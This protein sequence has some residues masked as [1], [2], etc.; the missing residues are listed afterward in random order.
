MKYSFA[1]LFTTAAQA[2]FLSLEDAPEAPVWAKAFKQD[3]TEDVK[4]PVIGEHKTK[5]TYYFDVS[6]ESN[7]LTRIDRDNGDYDRYCGLTHHFSAGACQQYITNGDRYLHYTKDDDCCYC[8][9]ADH[10]C[11]VLKNDWISD[12]EFVD[13][14]KLNGVDVL[15]WNK[16]GAQANWYFETT[17]SKA[18]DRTPIQTDMGVQS[19]TE[20]IQNFLP[21]TYTTDFDKSAFTLPSSCSKDKKCPVNSI[22]TALRGEK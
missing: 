6:D 4:Y 12:G 2:Q 17:E 15:K 5:G 22:C 8:C 18:E 10:G 9:S 1:I 16:Q 20:F 11:G 21:E 3:F 13:T 14:E 7:M 19:S